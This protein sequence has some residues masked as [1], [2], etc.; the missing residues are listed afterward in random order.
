MRTAPD[1]VISTEKQP[2]LKSMLGLIGEADEPA[3]A[4]SPLTSK[5]SSSA[6]VMKDRRLI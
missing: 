6:Q 3:I 4:K 1:T 5:L 2:R